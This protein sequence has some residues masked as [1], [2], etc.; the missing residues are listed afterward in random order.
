MLPKELYLS[1]STPVNPAPTLQE[2]QKPEKH[3]EMYHEYAISKIHGILYINEHCSFIG[4]VKSSTNFTT[5]HRLTKAN[6]A[7]T[8][9]SAPPLNNRNQQ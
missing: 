2:I 7:T 3:N 4:L 5:G 9:L 8:T 1:L 6:L